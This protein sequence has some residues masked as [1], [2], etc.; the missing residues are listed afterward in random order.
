MMVF[1]KKKKVEEQKKPVEPD[2]VVPQGEV[3]DIE[4]NVETTNVQPQQQYVGMPGFVPEN[5]TAQQPVIQQPV[6]KPMI[7]QKEQFQIIAAE[8][9][10]EGVYRYVLLTNKA[11]GEVGEVYDY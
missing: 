2:L 8:L 9:V 4:Q 7:K 6:Q 5:K 3:P 10:G 11:L 1:G